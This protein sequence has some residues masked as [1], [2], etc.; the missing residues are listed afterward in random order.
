[1]KGHPSALAL[2]AHLLEPSR[3]GLGAHLLGCERCRARV[4]RMEKDGEDFRRFV[5]PATLDAVVERQVRPRRPWLALVALAPAA[6]AALVFLL[7]RSGG[8]GDDYIGT[9][10]GLA[11]AVYSA[12]PSG[13]EAVRDGAELPAKSALRFRVQPPRPCHLSIASVD[14]TGQ[15][16]RIYPPEGAGGQRFDAGPVPGGAVLDGKV[17]LERFYA[18]CSQEPVPFSR[19]EAAIRSA[20]VPGAQSVRRGGALFGLPAES[21]QATVLV[22]KR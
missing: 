8:P 13:V 3:S 11:L 7:V 16:S 20:V 19:I 4:A 15:I 18:V 12:G 2:E 14:E 21:S 17:G 10:G 22:Q 9:K 5:L 1:M 6:A